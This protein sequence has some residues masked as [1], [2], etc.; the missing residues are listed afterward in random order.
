M[1]TQKLDSVLKRATEV[2][3]GPAAENTARVDQEA[4]WP[5]EGMRALQKAG[6]GG[7]V[8]PQSSGGLGYGLSALAQVCEIL[9]KE[10]AST[11]LCYGMHSVGTA[12]IAAKATPVQQ[13]DFLE[14][15][16]QGHHLTTLALSEPGSGSHFYI[17]EAKLIT[18]S[19]GSFRITGNKSFVTNGAF[20]D[21]YVV[22]TA[23]ADPDSPPGKFSCVVVPDKS[24]GMSW[25]NPWYGMG[26]RG[27]ASCTLT[28]QD[29]L[30]PRKNLLG[31]E[32][33]QI[34]YVFEVIARYFLIAMAGSYLG[35]AQAAFNE[36]KAHLSR[37]RHSHS[38]SVLADSQV[39]QHR[40]GELWIKLERARRLIYHA[41]HEGDAGSPE[42]ILP[43]FS[44]KAEVS[45]CAVELANE[46]MTLM[47]G[48]AYAE[49]SK[50]ARILR[51]ARASH[52]MS[53]TT[54]MLK[55]WMGRAIL[56]RPILG[57]DI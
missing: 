34:W 17:P 19:D 16:S 44:A 24:K 25:G 15:I 39:L 32:G 30:V 54:E 50:A 14:P 42:S 31:A 3:K 9:A 22:S 6:L 47:G 38:G 8:A 35:L 11:A 41:A 28:L 29:T 56:G 27:N 37:R 46:A 13:T 33:D 51:D 40:L 20:A 18:A 4:K 55:I 36:A 12:V 45:E 48:A 5:K 10:C 57:A 1:S 49:N 52:V 26:M 53:P 2:A 21:S 23:A 7:L 43:I